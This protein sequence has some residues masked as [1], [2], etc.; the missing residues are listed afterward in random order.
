MNT[1]VEFIIRQGTVAD[2]EELLRV[3]QLAF[4]REWDAE[5]W[6]RLLAAKR[7]VAPLYRVL[8]VDGRIVS[9]AQVSP[10]RLRLGRAAEVLKGDVGGVATLPECQGQGYGHALLRDVTAWMRENGY[11]LSRLGGYAKFYGRFGYVPMPRRHVLFPVGPV[12]AGATTISPEEIYKPPADLAGTLRLY[13]PERDAVRCG[14][15][16]ALFNDGRSGAFL[17]DHLSE[18]QVLA[19]SPAAIPDLNIVYEAKGAMQGYA[20]AHTADVN[21]HV[22]QSS[23]T[24]A[25][26]AINPACPEALVALIMHMLGEA[27]RR[28][29]SLVMARMP[30]DESLFAILRAEKLEF[31]LVEQ[32]E[33][34]A[35]NMMQIIHLE[36]LLRAAAPELAANLAD[37]GLDELLPSLTLEFT[38]Y[39]QRATLAIRNGTVEMTAEVA[40]VRLALDQGTLMKLLFGLITFAEADFPGKAELPPSVRAALTGLFPRQACSGGYALG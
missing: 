22:S 31:R 28:G 8:V 14:D 12:R 33:G 24:V 26:L 9:Q 36:S 10:H 23:V 20:L 19:S 21:P 37:A 15:L 27:H 5:E 7:E 3:E 34:L 6:A 35:S 16:R 32:N 39:D 25:D 11:H 40:D 18:G 1:S 13:D 30:F 29:L 2:A 17:R 4:R 38:T